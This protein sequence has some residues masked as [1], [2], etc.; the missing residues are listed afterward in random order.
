MGFIKAEGVPLPVTLFALL[1]GFGGTMIGIQAILDPSTAIDFVEGADKMGIAWGGRNLGLG[2]IMLV[3]VA[4]R[5][6]A[7]YAVGFSGVIWREFSDVIAGMS[8]GGSFNFLFAFVLVLELVCLA[9]C[10][11]AALAARR[12]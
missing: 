1:M 6:P 2:V 4:L 10:V 11:R 8:E 7:G 12:A 9:I 3:A 5:S